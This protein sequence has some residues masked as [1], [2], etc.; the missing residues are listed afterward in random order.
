MTIGSLHAYLRESKGAAMHHD[1]YYGGGGA[2]PVVWLLLCMVALVAVGAFVWY[3]VSMIHQRNAAAPQ[4]PADGDSGAL[5]ILGER[6]ARGEIDEEEY[7]RRRALL[8]GG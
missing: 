6:F 4:P 8:R 3:L 5:R 7:T 1:F 2:H